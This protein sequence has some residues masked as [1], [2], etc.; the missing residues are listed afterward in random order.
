[1]R[2]ILVIPHW[3]ITN[4]VATTRKQRIA[5][6]GKAEEPVKKITLT[7]EAAETAERNSQEF[8]ACSA[9]NVVIYSPAV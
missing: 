2:I 3:S 7:A 8:S 5:D 6:H 9:L 1:V 4:G